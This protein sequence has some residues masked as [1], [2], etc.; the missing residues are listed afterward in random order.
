LERGKVYYLE[1]ADLFVV[2][3]GLVISQF[4]SA[5]HPPRQEHG[6]PFHH[7]FRDVDKVLVDGADGAPVLVLGLDQAHLQV[8]DDS[9]P[10]VLADVGADA[11]G[12]CPVDKVLPQATLDTLKVLLEGL[13]V[14]IVVNQVLQH[15]ARELVHPGVEGEALVDDLAGKDVFETCVHR[16]SP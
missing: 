8:G 9:V 2:H 5:P 6:I 4:D 13:F 16:V 1:G 11:L 15:V 10:P 12:L 14:T 3:L 7:A